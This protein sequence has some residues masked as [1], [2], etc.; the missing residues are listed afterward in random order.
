MVN[1]ALLNLFLLCFDFSYLWL[2]SW[3]LDHVPFVARLYDPVKG[4]DPDPLVG[5]YVG[6]VDEL[7]RAAAAGERERALGEL[8][9][10]NAELARYEPFFRSG[11]YRE[12]RIVEGRI[13]AYVGDLLGVDGSDLPAE[14]LLTRLWTPASP[15]E[16]TRTL[17]FFDL[18]IRPVFAVAYRRELDRTGEY[19]DHGWL[20]DLPFLVLFS[21][22]F[23][24]RW[25]GAVRR[26]RYPR[27][28]VFP[29]LNWYDFLGIVPF[30]QFRVFRLFR[31]VSIYLRLFR[32]CRSRVGGDVFSRTASYFAGVAS[33]ELSAR[34]TVWILEDLQ[35]KIDAGVHRRIIHGV[36]DQRREAIARTLTGGLRRVIAAQPFQ[37]DARSFLDANLERAADASP[38]LRRIPLPK[39]VLRP[40]VGVVG[41]IVFDATLETLGETLASPQGQQT[42][43]KMLAGAVDG[44]VEELTEGEIEALVMEMVQDS[45]EQMKATVEVR[46]WVQ[47]L[48]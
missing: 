15:A 45:L 25:I 24:G 16:L 36:V 28:F 7:E 9:G 23:Y 21:I 2:R 27:W 19:A 34:T 30:P 32:S 17:E 22:E 20:L 6:L 4:I 48:E 33:E 14:G 31:I 12:L 11:Q 10:L 1:L 18:E 5:R 40:L 13:R 26:R 43:E 47:A 35:Q 37:A 3:Y 44:L 39:A 42:V 46:E 29:I 41:R 38:S 8:R